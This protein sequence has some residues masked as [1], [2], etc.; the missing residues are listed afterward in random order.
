[1]TN[2]EAYAQLIAQQRELAVL[3][4][5]SAVL[6]WDQQTYMPRAGAGFRG[7]QLALLAKLCHERATTH[8][9]GECLDQLGDRAYPA[10]SEEAA[11][12]HDVRRSYTRQ[13]KLS[14]R[15]VEELATVTTLAQEAWLEARATNHF[16]LFEPHLS[17][18][19]KLKREEAQAVGV[20]AGGH[21][22]DALLDEYEPG[23]TTPEVLTLFAD[24]RRELVPMIQAAKPTDTGVLHRAFPVDRQRFFA[25]GVA[26]A[27]GF[28]FQ[29]GRLDTT[30]HPFCSAFGP[31]D[32]RITTRFN[33]N[34]FN[35]AF[36]GVLHEAGHGM[37]EQ[38]LRPQAFGTACGSFASL[39]FHESQS[40]FW[41]NQVGRSWPFWQGCLPRLKQAFPG[42][43]DGASPAEIYKAVNS[44]QP[45]LIRVEA[46][47]LTYNLH[48]GIRV[49][50]ELAMISG[51]LA[52]HDLPGAWNDA[53]TKQL[54]VTPT[55]D[56]EGCLQDIHWSF[57]GFGYFATYTLGNLYAS[58]L[59]AA[60]R[61]QDGDWDRSI[62]NFEVAGTLGWLRKNVHGHGRRFAPQELCT[63]ATGTVLSAEFWLAEIREKVKHFNEVC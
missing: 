55:I 10:D 6:G 30:A 35:E 12:I 32:C 41:E 7:E 1:M 4:S 20:P 14:S 36:F 24:L 47:Q 60:I 42:L 8:L 40:R 28:D 45:S 33:P 2:P 16:K 59:L 19:L 13:S 51:D 15:F 26:A 43:V 63:R 37:Y 11:N 29:A 46:D 17:A 50:L 44:V 31:G 9:V 39:G 52:V 49:E 25:E 62:R 61:R 54:G 21:L 48:I 3:Q 53:Y 23:A 56:A 22:Y 38:G 58:Q 34:H 27:M 57:G 5:C 18:V